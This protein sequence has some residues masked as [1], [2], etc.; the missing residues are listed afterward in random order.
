MQRERVN[1]SLDIGFSVYRLGKDIPCIALISGITKTDGCGVVVLRKVIEELKDKTLRG[2]III[3]PQLNE[4]GLNFKPCFNDRNEP[5]CK[6]ID[7]LIDIIPHHCPVIEILCKKGFIPHIVMPKNYEDKNIRT[8]I[9]AIPAEPVVKANLKSLSN[10]IRKRGHDSLT[11]VLSGSKDFSHS[12][13][14][15]GVELVLDLLSNLEF[16]KRRSKSIQHTYFN[17]YFLVKCD[18]KG[19]FIPSIPSGS[20]VIAKTTLGKLDDSEIASPINGLVLYITNPRLCDV[21][22]IVCVIASED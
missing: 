8:L 1:I 19:V 14:E 13:V 6:L 7:K 10:I 21:D 5:I 12:E 4:Y 17:G 15:Q 20:K 18:S 2:T 9:E 3:V 22:E 16:L 11:L